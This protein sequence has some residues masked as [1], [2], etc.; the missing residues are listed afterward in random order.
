MGRDYASHHFDQWATDYDSGF[1]KWAKT[2]P[3]I[4]YNDVLDTIVHL[5]TP[6]S[7]KKVL[8]LGVGTGNLAQRYVNLGC[9]IW[10]VDF[11]S[12]MLAIAQEKVPDIILSQFDIRDEWPI[13][14]RN[15]FDRIVSAYVFHHFDL[16]EKMNLVR[17]ILDE[18][19]SEGGILAIGD[20][21]FE[22]VVKKQQAHQRYAEDWDESEFYWVAD[23]V[24]EILR[25][26]LDISYHQ[27]SSIGG[28]YTFQAI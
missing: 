4:G 17:R 25:D 14:F 1:E 28:V 7:G 3:F 20:I 10:G 5:S 12:K 21:S 15:Q 2:F 6:V 19:L 26:E 9:S 16:S 11:S 23:E 22:T 24:I 8:D 18:R 27:V 13:R